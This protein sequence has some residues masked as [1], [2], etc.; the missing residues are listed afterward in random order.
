M[1][2]GKTEEKGVRGRRRGRGMWIV[3]CLR[4]KRPQRTLTYKSASGMPIIHGISAFQVQ[5]SGE[6]GFEEVEECPVE[7]LAS[8]M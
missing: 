5:E 8:R 3:Y 2:A 1:K 4:S 7:N 6:E